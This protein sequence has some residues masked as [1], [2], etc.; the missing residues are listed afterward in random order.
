V[1]IDGPSGREHLRVVRRALPLLLAPGA[2]AALQRRQ[3]DVEDEVA[4][5]TVP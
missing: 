1:T 5:E 2:I 4:V 3:A